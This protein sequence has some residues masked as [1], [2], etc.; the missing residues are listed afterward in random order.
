M[1]RSTIQLVTGCYKTFYAFLEARSPLQNSPTSADISSAGTVTSA[2][3]LQLTNYLV[4]V[5]E[6]SR[7][8]QVLYSSPRDFE[9]VTW[10][11]LRVRVRTYFIHVCPRMYVQYR[12]ISNVMG[13]FKMGKNDSLDKN[14]VIFLNPMKLA[15]SKPKHA[16]QFCN[17]CIGVVPLSGSAGCA[18]DSSMEY[19]ALAH[20][21]CIMHE[22]THSPLSARDNLL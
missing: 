3:S 13:V 19:V 20:T 22:P 5:S 11:H 15:P 17:I 14:R 18:A 16:Q 12:S 21:H 4:Q 10:L 8:E 2:L 7:Q 1:R 9:L 6:N